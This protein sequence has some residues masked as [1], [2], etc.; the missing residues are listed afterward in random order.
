VKIAESNAEKLFT[1]SGMLLLEDLQKFVVK[2]LDNHNADPANCVRL[3]RR[4]VRRIN[5][6]RAHSMSPFMRKTSYACLVDK[7]DEVSDADMALVSRVDITN[8][9]KNYRWPGIFDVMNTEEAA[10]RLIQKWTHAK[11]EHKGS[12]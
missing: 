1:A 10:F 5:L 6:I 11:K 4:S 12:F 2:F 7:I 8:M 9:L 3:V